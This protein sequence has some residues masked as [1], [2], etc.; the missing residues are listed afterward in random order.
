MKQFLLDSTFFNNMDI[1][2]NFNVWTN[3]TKVTIAAG[4]QV[5]GFYSL[6]ATRWLFAVKWQYAAVKAGVPILPSPVYL[7]D[8][9]P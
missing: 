7:L 6:P 3:F 8:V 9:L 5:I 2:D 4:H 1:G